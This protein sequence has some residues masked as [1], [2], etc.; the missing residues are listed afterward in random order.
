M[1]PKA[2]RDL[3]VALSRQPELVGEAATGRT[4]N[5]IRAMQLETE[6]RNNPA[7]RADRFVENWQRLH[8]QRDL[9]MQSGNYDHTKSVTERMGRMAKSLERDPQ[10]DSLLR[11]RKIELGLHASRSGGFSHQLTEYL[12]IGR[13]I[14]ISM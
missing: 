3:S 10:V 11:N 13:G 2:D 12:G 14:G 9:S 5:T 8:R 1:Q 7:L 6:I 4:A